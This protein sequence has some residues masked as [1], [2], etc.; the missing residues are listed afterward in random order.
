[1]KKLKADVLYFSIE[2]DDNKFA[3]QYVKI[4]IRNTN[5]KTNL[6]TNLIAILSDRVKEE[7]DRGLFLYGLYDDSRVIAGKPEVIGVDLIV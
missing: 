1:M 7:S 3:D 6:Y 5:R 4:V 2:R